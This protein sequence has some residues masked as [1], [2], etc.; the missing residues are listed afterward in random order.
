MSSQLILGRRAAPARKI[1]FVNDAPQKSGELVTYSGDGHLMTF[2]PTGTGK[3]SGPVICNALKHPGQLIVMDI[4][5]EIHAA[6]AKARRAMGQE[7]H[8]LDMRDRDPLSGSLNPLDLLALSGTDHAAMARGFAAEIIERTGEERDGFWNDWAETIIAGGV[9]WLL[10]D[11]P[12]EARRLSAVF[13]LF[14]KE[15]VDYQLAC[16][17]DKDGEIVN[18]AARAAF[19]SY[20]QLPGIA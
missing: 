16:L 5:G 6:T 13:D 19:G 9:A 14:N 11:K 4:K 20:L 18:R 1:G 7:V 17:M 15:D 3:T 8:V 12:K 2:A 10:A